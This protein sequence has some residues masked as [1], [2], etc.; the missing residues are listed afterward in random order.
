VRKRHGRLERIGG[1][2]KHAA[3]WVA[4][5][6][7]AAPVSARADCGAEADAVGTFLTT[8]DIPSTAYGDADFV[9]AIRRKKIEELVYEPG[10]VVV[11]AADGALTL[12]HDPVADADALGAALSAAIASEQGRSSAAARVTWAIDGRATWGT[13]VPVADAIRGA[14]V[15][16]VRF[17]TAVPGKVAAPERVAIDDDFDAVLALPEA[18]RYDELQALVRRVSDPCPALSDVYKAVG[19]ANPADR[20]T[21]LLGGIGP[22]LRACEC[23]TDPAAIRAI[24]FRMNGTAFPQRAFRAT[25]AAKGTKVAHPADRPWS[26]I[27]PTVPAKKKVR[28][29]VKP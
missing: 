24:M 1:D 12:D 21:T 13:I 20:Q 10:H 4:L 27:A 16:A 2:M 26:Q 11:T 18:K 23:A 29:V 14:G 28:L 8:M 5:A 22:A 19:E 7:L 17:V 25:L 6:G 3:I 9:P 15:T